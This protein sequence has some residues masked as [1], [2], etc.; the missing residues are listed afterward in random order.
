MNTYILGIGR[1]KDA[2][3]KQMLN[4]NVKIAEATNLNT[5]PSGS[6]LLYI[7]DFFNK[8]EEIRTAAYCK[9]NSIILL[10]GCTLFDEAY[11]GPLF[12]GNNACIS[13]V[14]NALKNNKST[15]TLNVFDD[16]PADSLPDSKDM[17][18]IALLIANEAKNIIDG[19]NSSLCNTLEVVTGSPLQV[20]KHHIES[21]E[22]CD[23]CSQI[24]DD[25]PE[26]AKINFHSVKKKSPENYRSNA[27]PDIDYMRY[28]LVDKDTGK[29]KHSF[30]EFASQFI[31]FVGA[32]IYCGDKIDM[33]YGRD[34]DYILSQKS[35]ILEALERYSGMFPKSKKTVVRGSY[36]ELKDNA[37]DPHIFGLHDRSQLSQ[38]GFAY[39][40]YTDSLDISWVWAWSM[41]KNKPVLIPE[42]IAYYAPEL[43]NSK[44][45]RF[46]FETSNGCALG[47]NA[48]EA[49]IYGL[50][51][52]IER[53][54]FL[55]SWYN[56]LE[57]T[58]IDIDKSRIKE[59]IRLKE[60]IE[61]L[62]YSV[63]FF[64]MS[65]ELGLPAVWGLII[66][67]NGDPIVKTYSAAGAH[68][69]PESALKGA[70]LE[71]ITSIS[72][73]EKK[74]T[75]PKLQERRELMYHDSNEVT[76]FEDHVLL[77]SHPMADERFDYLLKKSHKKAPIQEIYKEWYNTDIYKNK[78]LNE[79]IDQLLEKIYKYYDDVYVINSTG[80]L[81][82]SMNLECCKVIVPGMNTMSFGHQYR[83]INIDRVLNGP[84]WAGRRKTPIDISSINT[85]PHPF[86]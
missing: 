3:L 24:P 82:D 73:Y 38:K 59:I 4:K 12:T 2:V 1:L 9:K 68:F 48:T 51:E 34:Y 21:D 65:M 80:K 67:N 57:L 39:K 44:T 77:Y 54:N 22:Y 42:Q 28:R 7:N 35:A 69:N 74:Y 53:D 70:L 23:V 20:I 84:V 61:S 16:I 43:I 66:N 83:R 32:E 58:E 46:V 17:N 5:V 10:R 63:H 55:V 14:L 11:I 13:C 79:D 62:N 64:D 78:T 8:N 45:N 56:K 25:S 81:L 60:Y 6:F 41:K 76:E 47:S 18:I 15:L 19:K 85:L 50:F 27:M 33:G 29:I 71:I 26:L 52:Y 31:P 86:P 37:V 30:T 36:S 75:D 72:I 49:F 40:E